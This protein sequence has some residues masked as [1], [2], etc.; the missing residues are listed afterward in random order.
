MTISLNKI[1]FSDYIHNKIYNK[2]YDGNLII[3]KLKKIKDSNER[4]ISSND[5]QKNIEANDSLSKN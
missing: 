5:N 3:N 2:K 1:K 4:I